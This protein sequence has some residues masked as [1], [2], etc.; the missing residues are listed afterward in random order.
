MAHVR[1]P[2]CAVLAGGNVDM[3]QTAVCEVLRDWLIP[4]M[5]LFGIERQ[6]YQTFINC[7]DEQFLDKIEKGMRK[8]T[9]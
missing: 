6:Y 7:R 9:W 4:R 8:F 1:H 2:L 5:K 3:Y